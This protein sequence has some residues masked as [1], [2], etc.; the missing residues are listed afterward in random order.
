MFDDLGLVFGLTSQIR[1][2][3]WIIAMIVKLLGTVCI[4]DIAP[5]FAAD[6]VVISFVSRDRRSVPGCLGIFQ[7]GSKTGPFQTLARW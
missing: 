2:F 4:A 1:P 6:G 7:Q 3:V 5:M